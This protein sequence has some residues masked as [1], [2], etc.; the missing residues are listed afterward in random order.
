MNSVWGDFCFVGIGVGFLFD[1]DLRR[2]WRT[3]AISLCPIGLAKPVPIIL[4][5]VAEGELD[6]PPREFIRGVSL[7]DRHA[8]GV[9]V[10]VF[11]L[12]ETLP[13]HLNCPAIRCGLG[14]RADRLDPHTGDVLVLVFEG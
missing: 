14:D 2:R 1:L 7:H 9:E 10:P 12:V 5:M 3:G 6:E 13:V 8:V 4:L 11:W